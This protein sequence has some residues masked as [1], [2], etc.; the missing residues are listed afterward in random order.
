MSVGIDAG[1]SLV[2]A[3]AFDRA[4]RELA[5]EARPVGPELRGGAVE[6]DAE[7]VYGAVAACS[8]RRPRGCR[9]RWS[10]PG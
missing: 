5:V 1:T 2:K 3:A 9:N 10:R 6:Q 8:A 4:G 7:E